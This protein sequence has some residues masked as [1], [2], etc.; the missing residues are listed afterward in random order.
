MMN[1]K[2]LKNRNPINAAML[3][4][5]MQSCGRAGQNKQSMIGG[6]NKHKINTEFTVK[7]KP[8]KQDKNTFKILSQI[9]PGSQGHP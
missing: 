8:E 7:N 4:Q 9:N 5:L 2:S 6:K 1:V 3:M